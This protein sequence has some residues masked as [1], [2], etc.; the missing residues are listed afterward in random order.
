M[1]QEVEQ[2]ADHPSQPGGTF[3]EVCACL[4][5][6][7]ARRADARVCTCKGVM[8]N[9]GV[10]R[11]CAPVCVCVHPVRAAEESKRGLRSSASP[12][13]CTAGARAA[14]CLRGFQYPVC[15]CVHVCCCVYPRNAVHYICMCVWLLHTLAAHMRTEADGA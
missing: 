8:E 6:G 10:Q 13:S 2:L 12:S 7:Y 15:V 11:V 9:A 5:S 14:T 3:V 1:K 4:L